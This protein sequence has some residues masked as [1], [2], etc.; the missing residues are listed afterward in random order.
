MIGLNRSRHLLNQSDVKPKE[1]ATWSHA[2]SRAWR[3]FASSSHW[4]IVLF[5]FLVI[6]H[7]NC[8][9]FDFDFTTLE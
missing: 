7:C 8:F 9:A 5:A 3:A 6:G 4:F 1:N 2:F